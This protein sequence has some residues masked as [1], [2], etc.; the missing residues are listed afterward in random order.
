MRLSVGKW[1]NNDTFRQ[2]TIL[3][4]K[5]INLQKTRKETQIISSKLYNLILKTI[6]CII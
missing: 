2:C 3:V 1:I 4:I 6:N 5:M